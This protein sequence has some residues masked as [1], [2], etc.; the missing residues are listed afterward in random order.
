MEPLEAVLW[1]DVHGYRQV[2]R[3]QR[4]VIA[5]WSVEVPSVA[6]EDEDRRECEQEQGEGKPRRPHRARDSVKWG[7][8]RETHMKEGDRSIAHYT[9][10]TA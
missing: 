10:P 6:A 2:M 8:A 5:C 4:V 7:H 1:R 3:G 9:I